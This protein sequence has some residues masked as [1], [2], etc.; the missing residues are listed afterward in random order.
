MKASVARF[1]AI[2]LTAASLFAV[3]P[4]AA[5]GSYG[6]MSIVQQIEQAEDEVQYAAA[7]YVEAMTDGDREAR[8]RAWKNLVAQREYLAQLETRRSAQLALR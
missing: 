4:A 5:C 7:A 3:V 1:V 6:P 2:A 8:T